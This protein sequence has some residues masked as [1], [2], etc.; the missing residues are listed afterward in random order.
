[1]K[2]GDLVRF[3]G[4]RAPH[5]DVSKYDGKTCLV[6]RNFVGPREHDWVHVLMDGKIRPF[7]TV[8]LEVIDETR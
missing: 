8:F 3:N 5:I 6:I 4:A 2:P 7:R 1:M